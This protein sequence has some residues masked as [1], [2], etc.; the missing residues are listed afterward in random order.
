VL[1]NKRIPIDVSDSA[2]G[3]LGAAKLVRT[4]NLSG[5]ALS[6]Y[7]E[8]GSSMTGLRADTHRVQ[9]PL[10]LLLDPAPNGRTSLRI[11]LVASAQDNSG[12]SNTPVQCGSTGAL[13]NELRRAINEQLKHLPEAGTP[14]GGP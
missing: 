5:T 7:L 3:F 4:R 8:C 1:Q 12:T 6:R 9:M 11:A 2:T 14:G 13:E 10:L